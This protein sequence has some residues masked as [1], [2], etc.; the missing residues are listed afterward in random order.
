M[1]GEREGEKNGDWGREEEMGGVWIRLSGV[2][3]QGKDGER[4]SGRES[5]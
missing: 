2:R 3:G 1:D 5:G 4:E